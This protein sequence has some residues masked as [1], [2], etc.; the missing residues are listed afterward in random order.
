[1]RDPFFRDL[2]KISGEIVLVLA[3]HGQR[4]VGANPRAY[5][6]LGYAKKDLIAAD[7][8]GVFADRNAA[9]E[10]FR[11]VWSGNRQISSRIACLHKGGHVTPATVRARLLPE[12]ANHLA[13]VVI[14]PQP[15]EDWPSR[16]EQKKTLSRL[17]RIPTGADFAA[18]LDLKQHVQ[19]W[20]K[21]VCRVARFPVAH[22][23]LLR[24]GSFGLSRCT[25]AWHIGPGK[26]L[27]PLRSDPFRVVLPP[28]F[29]SRVAAVGAPQI[30]ADL[31]REPQFRTTELRKLQLA[32]AIAIPIVVGSEVG[33]T[34]VFYSS[35]RLARGSLLVD[36]MHIL[37]REL[38]CAMHFRFVSLKLTNVQEEERRRLAAELHDTV[39]QS[40]SILLLD[41][42]TVQQEEDALSAAGSAA[43]GRGIAAAGQSLQEVRTLSYL[44]HPPLLEALGLLP[45]LRVFIQGF[46][47]RSGIRIVSELPN[48]LPRVSQDWEMAVFRVVQEGLTNVQRHSRSNVAQ[49]FMTNAAGVV[50][51][52]VINDG[53]S[54]PAL[55]SGGLPTE[56]V[57]VGISGMRE[58]VR[59][60]GGDVNLFSCSGKTVLEASIPLPKNHRSPQLR[61]NF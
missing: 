19:S 31:R 50:N 30:V 32:S 35:D 20:L 22:F 17:L 49:V 24:D 29:Y 26:E 51:V 40:L 5:K 7:A 16:N 21:R 58:R 56:K 59:A 10:F 44:L 11:T 38:G 27:D 43:L 46:S 42:E 14:H 13:L 33:A 41:L 55:E 15:E 48:S 12:S 2:S 61:L 45:A 34:C 60:F 53:A 9:E 47:R 1:L 3:E 25:D 28:E 4:L 54:A 37:G 8:L 52:Q 23:H 57:G 6:F 39:A 36:V 18:V